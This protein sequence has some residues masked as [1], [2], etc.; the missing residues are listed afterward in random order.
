MTLDDS[1]DMYINVCYLN[2]KIPGDYFQLIK[3]KMK[4]IFKIS[5]FVYFKQL[6]IKLACK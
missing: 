1:I 5:F 3:D 2:L 6:S 4:K